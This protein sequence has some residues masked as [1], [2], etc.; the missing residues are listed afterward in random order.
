MYVAQKLS[1]SVKKQ[2]SIFVMKV[3]LMKSFDDTLSIVNWSTLL[4][5][6]IRPAM[7]CWKETYPSTQMITYG[8]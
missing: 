6:A 8:T 4:H 7:V 1:I 3:F 5:I 2:F